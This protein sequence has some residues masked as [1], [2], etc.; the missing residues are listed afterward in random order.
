MNTFKDNVKSRFELY[1]KT[2]W[3]DTD[4][5]LKTFGYFGASPIHRRNREKKND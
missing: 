3:E 4:V 1:A 5:A 2:Q